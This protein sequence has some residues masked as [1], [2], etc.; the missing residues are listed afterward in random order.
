[1]LDAGIKVLNEMATFDEAKVAYVLHDDV[2]V[3]NSAE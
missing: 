2:P 3:I 1:M